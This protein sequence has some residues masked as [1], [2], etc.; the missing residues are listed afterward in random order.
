MST[1]T[2]VNPLPATLAHYQD[3]MLSTLDGTGVLPTVAH[4]SIEGRS[5][6]GKLAAVFSSLGWRLRRS[7]HAGTVL[8][9]WPVF[10]YFDALTWLWSARRNRVVLIVHDVTPLRRQFGHSGFA[11]RAFRF[12]VRRGSLTVVCHTE[13]AA[14][15]LLALTGVE[16]DVASHPILPAIGEHH[17]RV[18]V[19]RVL[20]QYKTARDLTVLQTMGSTGVGPT[21]YSLEIHGRGWPE[22]EGWLTSSGFVE[23]DAFDRLVAEAACVIIPYSKFYQ[24]GVI[25]RCLENMTPVVSVRHPQVEALFGAD[26]PGIVTEDDWVAAVGRAVAV[27]ADMLA[28]SLAEAQQLA[29]TE[30][31]ASI[32]S[33]ASAPASSG[34]SA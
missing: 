15:E 12:A 18:P 5:A 30:W 3:E 25:I 22:V 8:V 13:A 28:R 14:A 23:E 20:G 21:G 33:S 32:R 26:W 34:S 10:G 31:S 2:L 9:L 11:H 7:R 29:A 6:L 17:P 24:S 4:P 16:A 1:V 27:P 19:V